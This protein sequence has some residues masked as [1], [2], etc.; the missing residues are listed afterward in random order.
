MLLLV[1]SMSSMLNETSSIVT[2]SI[3]CGT[4]LSTTSKSAAVSPPTGL[5]PLVSSMSTRTA[6]IAVLNTCRGASA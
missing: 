6:S 4:P 5:L 3:D 1:S 2:L